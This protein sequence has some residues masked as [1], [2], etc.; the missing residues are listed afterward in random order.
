MH[1][2]QKIIVALVAVLAGSWGIFGFIVNRYVSNIDSDI[3][4]LFKRTN[5][6]R[7][8]I[9]AIKAICSERHKK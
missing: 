6:D 7:N 8:D 9:S 4:E 1:D 2:L 3:S 5:D